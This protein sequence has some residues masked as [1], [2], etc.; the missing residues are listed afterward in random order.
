MSPISV[1]VET[2]ELCL[3]HVSQTCFH[4]ECRSPSHEALQQASLQVS[5]RYR[6]LE[7]PR[8]QFAH[9]G[10]DN[11]DQ[12]VEHGDRQECQHPLGTHRRHDLSIPCVLHRNWGDAE[13][14]RGASSEEGEEDDFAEMRGIPSAETIQNIKRVKVKYSYRRVICNQVQR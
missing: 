12:M 8:G 11:T 14:R 9:E 6:Y 10:H 4:S 3:Q 5:L 2:G 7:R 1:F 13:N